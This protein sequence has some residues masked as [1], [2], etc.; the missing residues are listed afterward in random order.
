MATVSVFVFNLHGCCDSVQCE[1]F[2]LDVLSISR[3]FLMARGVYQCYRDEW[4]LTERVSSNYSSHGIILT[5][6]QAR[7]I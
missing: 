6:L 7:L 4:S 5:G 3:W 2:G 1:I